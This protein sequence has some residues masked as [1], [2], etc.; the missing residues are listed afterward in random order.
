MGG[1][2]PDSA[3]IL[4]DAAE[5][6]RMA[7]FATNATTHALTQSKFIFRTS[8]SARQL[9]EPFGEWASAQGHGEFFACGVDDNSG[10]ESVDAFVAGL[11]KHGGG[12][13]ARVSIASG[14][15]IASLL[16]AIKAQP[17]KNVFAAFT[18]DD[19]EAFIAEWGKQGLS[20]AGY[21]LFG[22]G[23]LADEEVLAQANA[24]AIGVMTSLFWSPDLDNAENKNLVDAFPKEYVDDDT[25]QPVRLS[26][27]AVQM[28]DAMRALDLALDKTGGDVSN[29][30]ALIASLEGVSFASPR[31]TFAFDQASH[32]PVQSMLV[33]EVVSSPSGKP[34]NS[35]AAKLAPMAVGFGSAQTVRLVCRC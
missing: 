28:W 24:A 12:A 5:S 2:S 29:V 16:A 17:T 35:I 33:R 22:P 11:A 1:A 20:Q 34:V 32:N 13:T 8:A 7:Y 9:C 4:R 27:Y 15:N 21:A 6:L 25:G 14:G 10:T 30:N 3:Q 18:T 23:S 31:G 19:A 26:G